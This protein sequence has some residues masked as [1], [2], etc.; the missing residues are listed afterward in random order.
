MTNFK[1]LLVNEKIVTA[2]KYRKK[3]GYYL[4]LTVLFLLL[5]ILLKAGDDFERYFIN[6]TLRID[7]YH[8]G[9]KQTDKITLDHIYKEDIWSGSLNNMV[10]HFNNGKYYIKLYDAVSNKLLFSKGYNSYFA[11]YKTTANAAKCIQ[12]TYHESALTPFPKKKV[13][14]SVEARDRNNRLYELFSTIIDP[15]SVDI[16]ENEKRS[17][18][19][20]VN[21]LVNGN[22]HNKV[23]LLFVAEGYKSDE[24]DKFKS[25][26]AHFCSYFFK[27]SPYRQ[28]KNNFNIRGV[29]KASLESGCDE[30]THGSYKNT[31]VETTFNSMGSPRY[32]LTENN[33]ELHD[34][35]SSAPY[36]ALLIMVNHKRY[37]GGGI[38]NFFLTF[39]SDNSWR[40]F[41]FIHEFGHSFA[42]LA[43]EYYSSSTAYDEFYTPGIEPLEPNITALLNPAELKWKDLVEKGTPIPTPWNKAQY[44]SLSSEYQKVRA[45]YQ[46]KI[47]VLKRE[48]V[49]AQKI[50]ELEKE[51]DAASK[52][53]AEEMKNLLDKGKKVGAYEGAGYLSKGMYRPQLDCI[54][55]SKNADG[56][57]KVC[58][59]RI[60]EMIKYYS[61]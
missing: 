30:P 52:R 32:L 46:K 17:D 16:I 21:Y 10:D 8:S 24:F 6:R 49:D 22:A 19:K 27:Q 13:R 12:R 23:D 34:I 54:M 42:G 39:T 2:I 51:A 14:F 5:P 60:V 31:A 26:L 36:D 3:T 58:E 4:H 33:R 9:D 53:Y 57:C 35:A 37:G 38:Y 40:D 44:D 29:F 41:V 11:E 50:N 47:A 59:R 15:V 18:V 28:N 56:Y 45:E 1:L 48:N 7:F 20:V 43:D 25:D 55:K 61:Q